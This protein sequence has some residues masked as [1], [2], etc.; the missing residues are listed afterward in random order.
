MAIKFLA[1]N[2][3]SNLNGLNSPIKRHR[4]VEQ[5]YKEDLTIV[6][7]TKDSLQFQKIQRRRV[8]GWK[9]IFQANSKQKETEVAILV[10]DKRFKLKVVKRD[11]EGPYIMIKGLIHQEEKIIVNIYASNITAPKSIKQ[12]QK[13]LKEEVNSDSIILRD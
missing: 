1:I 8:K 12:V 5:M 3:Y 13:K 2:N 4:V 9:K 6:L 7:P 11:R 10:S